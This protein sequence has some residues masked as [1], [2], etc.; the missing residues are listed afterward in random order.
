MFYATRRHA[1]TIIPS[2]SSRPALGPGLSHARNATVP[3]TAAA[4]CPYTA[5][6]G[7]GREAEGR[8]GKARELF[9][10][11]CGILEGKG[12]QKTGLNRL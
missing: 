1:Y 9:I 8:K 6:L 11:V 4:D 5:S 3:R 10:F 2:S 7:R 12:R